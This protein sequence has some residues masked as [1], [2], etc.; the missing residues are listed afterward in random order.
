[1]ALNT[2]PPQKLNHTKSNINHEESRF[3]LQYLKFT[4][5]SSFTGI[6]QKAFNFEIFLVRTK[7]TMKLYFQTIQ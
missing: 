7:N 5:V 3:K 6:G 1:M 2:P 4:S